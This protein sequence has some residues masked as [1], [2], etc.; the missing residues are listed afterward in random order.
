M[1]E[2]KALKEKY[3]LSIMALAHTPKRDMT[4]PISVNDLQGSKMLANFCD[5]MFAIGQSNKDSGL[6]YLR[7]LK[8]RQTGAIYHEE[9]VCV[10]EITKSGNFLKYE[11]LEFGNERE[12]LSTPSDNDRQEL[13]R[14]AAELEQQ[15]KTQRDIASILSVSVG[16]VNG[17]LKTAKELKSFTAEYVQDVQNV[18]D[19]APLFD[20]NNMNT[21]DKD[22]NDDPR[23]MKVAE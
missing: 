12:H 15:G 21:N 10:G 5:S 7:Q 23:N 22:D 3:G 8:S 1:K 4:K 16:K 11:F 2:L 17:L 13:V 14:K 19:Y 18:R 6:R 9:N 20:V